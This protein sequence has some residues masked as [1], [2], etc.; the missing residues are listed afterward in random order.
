MKKTVLLLFLLSSLLLVSCANENK[1]Q[2]SYSTKEISYDN[3]AAESA[4]EMA[5]YDK[6]SDAG[7]YA[8]VEY[9]TFS[10]PAVETQSYGN[11]GGAADSEYEK[12]VI[13]NAEMV[14]DAT[15]V[16]GCYNDILAFA[17]QNG[18]YEFSY[19]SNKYDE[20]F[21]INAVIKILPQNLEKFM[22]FA[23][24]SATLI[25]SRV[26]SNDISSEYYDSV[27]RLNTLH[28]SLD[29]Y[30][31]F[32][33]STTTVK[34]MLNVQNEINNLTLQIESYEGRIK[35]WNSMVG[36]ATVTI[37]VNPIIPEKPRVEQRQINWNTLS[38]DDM[39]Y[40]LKKGFLGVINV[41]VTGFQWLV[42]VLVSALPVIAVI[43]VIIIALILNKKRKT[44]NK[45]DELPPSE[46]SENK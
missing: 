8:D 45:S 24:D 44:K 35:Y 46:N 39:L 14:L 20:Y 7:G 5:V 13:K 12:K 15:D 6:V 33:E 23:G 2:R 25:S 10:S 22:N 26:Y 29:K 19:N 32:L 42:I 3:N 16:A 34:D 4:T 43:A 30:Y 28:K 18:G 17:K 27:T 36:E 1:V 31:E 40:L 21:Y 37:T 11:E 41:F 38:F 9:E